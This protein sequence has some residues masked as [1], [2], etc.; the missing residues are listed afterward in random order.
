MPTLV[1]ATLEPVPAFAKVAVASKTSANRP[2]AVSQ[3]QPLAAPA[4]SIG[5]WQPQGQSRVGKA[6][7][8][9]EFRSVRV[10]NRWISRRGVLL[11]FESGGHI[12]ETFAGRRVRPWRPTRFDRR[13]GRVPILLG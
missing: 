2:S 9:S 8:R 4:P 1:Q 3:L 12:R 11:Q 10:E 5:V 6:R 7:A 13:G